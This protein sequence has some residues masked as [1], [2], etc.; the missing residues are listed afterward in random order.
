MFETYLAE[1]NIS[2]TI[3]QGSR[4][5]YFPNKDMLVFINQFDGTFMYNYAIRGAGGADD[6]VHENTTHEYK[7]ALYKCKPGQNITICHNGVNRTRLVIGSSPMR[8]KQDIKNNTLINVVDIQ[9]SSGQAYQYH[10]PSKAE[11]GEFDAQWVCIQCPSNYNDLTKSSSKTILLD[12]GDINFDGRLD[13]QDYH[14]LARYTATGPG[15]E[16][17][18]WEPTQKQLTVMDTNRDGVINNKDAIRLKRFI[19]GDPAIPSLGV[20]PYTYTVTSDGDVSENISNLLI[21]DGWYDNSVNIPYE[22]FIE[23]DWI[24]HEKFFNYLLGMAIHKYSSSNNISYLQKLLKEVY[25]EHT[26]DKAYFY[27]GLYNDKMKD[28]VLKYQKSQQ[29]Y[30]YGDLNLDGAIDKID[31]RML[32]EYLDTLQADINGDGYADEKDLQLVSD[33]ISNP[34][35]NPLTEEQLIKADVNG[36]GVVNNIDYQLLKEM[37]TKSDT[38]SK[39]FLLRADVNRDGYV[40]ETDY[41]LMDQEVNQNAERLKQYDLTFILGWCD[42]DTESMIEDDVNSSGNLSEVSK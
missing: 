32:R 41:T 6:Q 4:K 20:I 11:D 24:I 14:L 33:Y 25:T 34:Y 22:D 40:N 8:L 38:F 3:Q 2:F 21:I 5:N 19:D 13:L 26:Y 7:I 9:L 42:C 30:T 31:L 36:D 23:D 16:S 18:K 35:I 15:A 29:H 28:L 27:P 12:V 37:V 10:C 1:G 17:M 39:T